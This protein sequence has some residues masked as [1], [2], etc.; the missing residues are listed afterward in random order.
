M[1]ITPASINGF[2]TTFSTMFQELY[3]RTETWWPQIATVEPT[4]SEIHK[5]A[6]QGRIPTFREWIGPR[7]VHGVSAQGYT[8]NVPPRE[9]TVEVDQFKLADDTYGVYST[10]AAQFGMQA[11]KLPDYLMI[12]A[13]VN[14]GDAVKGLCPDGLAFWSAVHPVDVYAPNPFGTYSNTYTLALTADNYQTVRQAMQVR[15]GQDGKPLAVRASE[16][17][18]PPALEAVGRQILEA[19]LIANQT[20]QGQTQVGGFSN[21]WKGTATLKVIPELG[22]GSNEVG[23]NDKTW[24]LFDTTK[25]VK[26]LLYVLRQ[27]AEM[28]YRVAPTDPVVFDKHMYLYG[29]V[30][31]SNYGYALPFLASRSVGS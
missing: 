5:V 1:M 15:L 10:T 31:R 28:T 12:D 6:W 13:L 11:K 19:E 21:I 4:K 7:E 3:L 24:Y 22:G 18:V 25:V 27:A 17:W 20:M 8:L 30:E 9:L 2:F 16:L 29:G 26:P 23:T 14:G